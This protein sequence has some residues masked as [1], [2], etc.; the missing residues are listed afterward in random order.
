MEIHLN[1][2]LQQNLQSMNKQFKYIEMEK[3]NNVTISTAPSH[4]KRPGSP[5]K[6]RTN[7]EKTSTTYKTLCVL[8]LCA[9]VVIV[10]LHPSSCNQTT[11]STKHSKTPRQLTFI[12]SII[13]PSNQYSVLLIYK[14]I[15]I[16]SYQQNGI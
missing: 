1:I 6:I 14:T 13:S 11:Q 4:T 10:S 5:Q 12:N 8:T 15:Y 7:T 16:H 2:I 9:F 3:K